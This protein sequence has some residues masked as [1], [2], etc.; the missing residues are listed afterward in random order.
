MKHLAF[1]AGVGAVIIDHQ[2]R[3][4]AFQRTTEDAGWQ[5]PQGGIEEDETPI[6]AVYREIYEETGISKDEI[7]LL[8]EYP[9][10]LVYEFPEQMMRKNML[11]MGQA[12][13]WFYFGFNC[14]EDQV[15]LDRA[16][17]DE[18]QAWEWVSMDELVSRAVFFK[19]DVYLKLKNW[20]PAQLQRPMGIQTTKHSN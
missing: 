11:L 20:K 18:F 13:R 19:K 3:V 8:G 12:H 14:R 4:L 15:S 9:D 17:D 1:R 2:G 5:L 6:Q 7:T 16:P 10:W